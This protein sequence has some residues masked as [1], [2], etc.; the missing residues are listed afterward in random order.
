MPPTGVPVDVI[1]HCAFVG[2]PDATCAELPAGQ[3]MLGVLADDAGV[4]TSTLERLT[5]ESDSAPTAVATTAPVRKRRLIAEI[6]T[7]PPKGLSTEM[8]S[9]LRAT[10]YPFDDDAKLRTYRCVT[11]STLR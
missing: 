2:P 6:R 8:K 10:G 3:L 9:N 5:P 7:S 4:P 1:T 11:G